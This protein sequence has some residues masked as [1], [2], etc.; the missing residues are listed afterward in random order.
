QAS[1][2]NLLRALD[3][4]RLTTESEEQL[5]GWNEGPDGPRGCPAEP[6]AVHVVDKDALV[7][8]AMQL[9]VKTQLIINEQVAREKAAQ[10]AA[11][12]ASAPAGTSAAPAVPQQPAEEQAVKAAL[13]AWRAAWA[14][15]DA[16]AYLLAYA[17]EFTPAGGQSREAW[18]RRRREILGRASGVTVE[19]TDVS[20]ALE[21]KDK[22]RTTFLQNYR[23]ASY[24]DSV[25]KTLEW[26]RVDGRWLIVR[27]TAE[28]ASTIR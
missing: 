14:K 16:G 23:S 5:Q 8:R 4:T 28:P 19:I 10:E 15:R 13:E 27:E 20:V 11:R 21:G 12:P 9:A 3:V 1:V 25:R 6:I 7:Q 22:A 2:G 24:G 26:Q 17:P 18:E